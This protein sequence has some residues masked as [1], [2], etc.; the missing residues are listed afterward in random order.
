M[1][2]SQ[3]GSQLNVQIKRGM[4]MRALA[5]LGLGTFLFACGTPNGHPMPSNGSATS[6]PPSSTRA[7]SSGTAPSGSGASSATPAT[8]EAVTLGMGEAAP[9]GMGEAAT[10]GM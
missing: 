1:D 3:M 4:G 8:E 2:S 6:A 7:G 9:P 10:P 5:L